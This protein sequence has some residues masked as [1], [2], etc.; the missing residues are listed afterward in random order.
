MVA[1]IMVNLSVYHLTPFASIKNHLFRAV[2][3]GG[4]SLTTFDRG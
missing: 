1:I 3:E 4:E 2:D